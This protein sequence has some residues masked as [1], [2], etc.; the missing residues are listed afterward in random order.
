M[1]KPINHKNGLCHENGRIPWTNM[2]KN[3]KV[4]N[5]VEG[6]LI[7][8]EM[9]NRDWN[10]WVNIHYVIHTNA[11]HCLKEKWMEK[12]NRADLE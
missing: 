3:D 5:S 6:K 2:K 4:L 10:S 8:L 9:I 12:Q 7:V 1:F 11:P